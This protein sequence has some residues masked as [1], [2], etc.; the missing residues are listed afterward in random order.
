MRVRILAM[1][2]WVLGACSSLPS[3]PEA[4]ALQLVAEARQGSLPA[5]MVDDAWVARVRRVQL[6]KRVPGERMAAATL[7]ELWR[8]AAAFDDTADARRQR[9]AHQLALALGGRCDAV[10]DP[11]ERTRRVGA[12]VDPVAHAPAEAQAEL[13]RLRVALR[14]SELV[15]VIC[16]RGQAAVLLEHADPWRV[17]DLY[18]LGSAELTVAANPSAT[19]ESGS[20]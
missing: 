9:A 17:V 7:A 6:F 19:R 10:R 1:A 2:C 12:L 16:E 4:F 11:D 3:Q 13:A 14:D 15:R 20:H 8:G 18:P 5:A